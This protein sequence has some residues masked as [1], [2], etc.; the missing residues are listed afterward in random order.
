MTTERFDF[1]S[2]IVG[3]LAGILILFV[4]AWFAEYGYDFWNQYKE[5]IAG[6]IMGFGIMYCIHK[7]DWEAG[8]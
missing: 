4:I 3:M 6:F 1:P 7:I 5:L 8:F 2:F